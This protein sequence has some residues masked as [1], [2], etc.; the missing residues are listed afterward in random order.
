MRDATVPMSMGAKGRPSR[1]ALPLRSRLSACSRA[2][3]EAAGASSGRSFADDRG[4]NGL[5][6]SCSVFMAPTSPGRVPPSPPECAGVS[7]A[8]SD[9]NWRTSRPEDGT[10]EMPGLPGP[11]P[12]AFPVELDVLSAKP[13]ERE[14][15]MGKAKKDSNC[16]V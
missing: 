5:K 9:D 2:R 15:D 4:L 16:E 11:V 14:E 10:P 6:I 8:T 12:F 13:T 3:A 7:R 1:S